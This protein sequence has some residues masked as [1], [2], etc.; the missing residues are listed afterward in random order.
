MA[1]RVRRRRAV[2]AA[3]DGVATV[4]MVSAAEAID[5]VDQHRT[6]AD[7]ACAAGVRHVVYTSFY[8]ASPEAT[9]TLARDHWATEVHLRASAVLTDP[10]RHAGCSYDLTGP[11]DLTF[12]EIAATLTAATGRAVTYLPETVA[13]AYASRA[14]FGAPDWQVTAWVSTYLA[15]AAGELSGVSYDVPRLTGHAA[16]PLAA[17]LRGRPDPAASPPGG[18]P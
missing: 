3:L 14:G 11:E 1:G 13:Q 15:V 7:A 10:A 4:F 12:H 17:V 5:R 16:T 18:P 6:F 9:F 2:R 8:R